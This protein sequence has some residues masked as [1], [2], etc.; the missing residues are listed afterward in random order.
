M[1]WAIW[2]L[3]ALWPLRLFGQEWPQWRGPSRDGH[4]AA[5]TAPAVW[6]KALR[7]AWKASVGLGHA[8]PLVAGERVYLFAR[9]GQD[10][11]LQAFDLQSGRALWRQ[12]YAAPYTMHPAATDH[13]PGPKATPLLGGGRLY[14]FG[15]TSVL[16]SHDAATGRLLWRKDFKG[17]F[18]DNVPTYGVAQ[19]PLLEG[20][21]LIAH[22]GGAQGALIA[23]DAATGQE[24]WSWAGDGPAYASPIVVEVGG[25]RQ[26]VT[27]T[28]SR[29]VGVSAA[30]GELLWTLPFTTPYEQNAVTPVVLGATVIASGLEGGVRALEIVKTSSGFKLEPRWETREVSMWMSSPVLVDGRLYGFSH[31]KKGEFFALDARTGRLLWRS[32]GR[33]GENASLIAAGGLLFA[34]VTDGELHVAPAAGG[35]WAP[36]ASYTVAPSSVWAHSALAGRVLAVKDVDSLIVWR[37]D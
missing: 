24:R 11:V 34:T 33:Q 10:E 37:L 21:L 32:P 35:S 23:F 25:V 31:L 13:G 28:R 6:P 17:R 15:I 16:S 20:G 36:L 19:S 8:S 26:V 18:A 14:T 7:Q 9:Q 4:A 5:F 2:M 27:F 29:L 30:R 22:V 12:A 3:L 1:R